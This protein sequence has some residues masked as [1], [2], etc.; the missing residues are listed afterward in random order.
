[1]P[2]KTAGDANRVEGSMTTIFVYSNTP[3]P[4]RKR[5]T[6]W[7]RKSGWN[8]KRLVILTN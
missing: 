4:N 2:I 7:K 3:K 8:K 6:G 5:K 1:M